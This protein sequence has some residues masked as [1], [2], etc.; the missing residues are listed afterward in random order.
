MTF[1]HVIGDFFRS[2]FEQ[3]PLSAVRWLFVSI[4]LAL[5]LWITLIPAER[6]TPEGRQSR[7]YEDLRIWAWLAVMFQIVI[8]ELF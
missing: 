2:L 5:L 8:Y 3:I 6:A 1:L 4:F 7:W